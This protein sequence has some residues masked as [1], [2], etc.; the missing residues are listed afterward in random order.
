VQPTPTLLR[1]CAHSYE[2]NSE[3][4]TRLRAE[5]AIQGPT[6]PASALV[7]TSTTSMRH[8]FFKLQFS[9]K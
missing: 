4:T 2:R 5:R 3:K 9:H 1:M 8:P 6:L 7:P